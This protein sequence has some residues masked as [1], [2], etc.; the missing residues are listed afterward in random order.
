[1]LKGLT[2]LSCQKQPILFFILE[3]IYF[4]NFRLVLKFSLYVP[5]LFKLWYSKRPKDDILL[6]FTRKYTKN[7]ILVSAGLIFMWM[8]L[9]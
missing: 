1:M 3:E 5:D 8:K 6:N 4:T 7:T 9:G 2:S